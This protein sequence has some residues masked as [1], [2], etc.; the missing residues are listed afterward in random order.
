ML[1]DL[2][3]L[4][5]RRFGRLCN[6]GDLHISISVAEVAVLRTPDHHL[7]FPNRATNLSTALLARFRLLGE[8]S[9]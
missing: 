2:G 8:H 6:T 5:L 9:D 1:T 7:D 3:V 4:F